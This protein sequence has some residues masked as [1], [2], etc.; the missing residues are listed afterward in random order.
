[1]V[2]Q[3]AFDNALKGDGYLEADL[4]IRMPGEEPR[5]IEIRSKTRFDD[6]H[7]PISMAGVVLDITDRRTAE[8]HRDLL[9]SELSHRVKNTLATVQAIVGRSLRESEVEQE[10]VTKISDRLKAIASVHD[11]LTHRGWVSANID[12]I[13]AEVIKPYNIRHSRIAFGGPSV[14]VSARAATSLALAL[15]ELAS[16]AMKYG[17]LS[18]QR[19]TVTINWEKD[20]DDLRL[21]WS[22]TGGPKVSE[23]ARRGFGSLLIETLLATSTYGTTDLDYRTDGLV[24]TFIAPRDTLL[25]TDSIRAY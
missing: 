3:T 14:S 2:W 19:G 20:G 18:N 21:V 23:P 10:L 13:I 9:T 1:M 7:Q 11:V 6:H 12:E 5:W 16:N 22:E 17:S 25:E 15:H 4:H 8:T 24:F